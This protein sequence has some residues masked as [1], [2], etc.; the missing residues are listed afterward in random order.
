MVE[1][2]V[3]RCAPGF[4][5]TVGLFTATENS[6]HPSMPYG[7]A[8]PPPKTDYRGVEQLLS[9]QFDVQRLE[10]KDK[11]VPSE[12]DVLLVGKAGQLTPNQQFAIDQYLMSGGT[13]LVFAGDLG[14]EPKLGR[15][16][17]GQVPPTFATKDLASNLTEFL[18]HYGVK[19]GPGWVA[20]PQN[21]DIVYPLQRSFGRT[22]I[23]QAGYP[24]FN[25]VDRGGFVQTDHP[26]LSGLPSL[27]FLWPT[28]LSF[29]QEKV[30]DLK[31]EVILKSSPQSWITQENT[32][33][34]N[35]EA[36]SNPV[37]STPLLLTLE[38]NFVSAFAQ[39][40]E[41]PSSADLPL[42]SSKEGKENKESTQEGEAPSLSS[43]SLFQ[44]F[45]ASGRVL[46]KA[47]SGSKLVV[48]GSPEQVSDLGLGIGQ[49][50]TGAFGLRG[51]YQSSI[52]LLQN[53]VEWAVEDDSLASLRTV[54]AS[55]RI[56][57]SITKDE[58][59]QYEWQQYA[60]AFFALLFL[61]LM[62]SLPR[63]TSP[64]DVF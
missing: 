54:G 2:G 26:I 63:M 39:L 22:Q 30:K 57:K 56:L 9:A 36:G 27:T 13:V 8:P 61:K 47:V 25:H 10:L 60:F 19:V 34:P 46:N 49:Y 33:E 3:R 1:S 40:K 7:Q 55:S 50:Y 41:R 48:I 53:L 58:Q 37:Q 29:D 21:L 20:D 16:N 4:K 17:N 42:N 62:T 32:L 24:F 51:D 52:L 15:G 14:I 59:V 5:K 23:I 12:I 38:G 43:A 45:K 64:E 18:A 44:K 6:D 31:S 11:L 35:I 28:P